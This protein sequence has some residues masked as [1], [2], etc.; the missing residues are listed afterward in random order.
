MINSFGEDLLESMMESFKKQ[1]TNGCPTFD[2]NEVSEIGRII[3]KYQL[4]KIPLKVAVFY[5]SK[6]AME[7]DDVKSKVIDSI[8][9]LMGKLPP[10]QPIKKITSE[11][12]V[13]SGFVDPVLD[14]LLSDPEQGVHLRWTNQK[15]N[16]NEDERPDAIISV[17]SQSQWGRTFGHGETKISEANENYFVLA[18]DLV[19]LGYFNRTTINKENVPC[20]LAFQSNGHRV[21]FYVTELNCSGIYTMTELASIEIPRSVVSLDTLVTRRSLSSLLLVAHS[22]NKIK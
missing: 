10:R 13:W 2:Q 12:E 22:F 7:V 8:R 4:R 14:S 1:W 15:E 3:D 18:K 9:R 5:L 16:D 19:R 6:L 21:T 20:A 17:L 11:T